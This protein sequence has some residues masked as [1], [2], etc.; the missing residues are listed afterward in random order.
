MKTFQDIYETSNSDSEL[1]SRSIYDLKIILEKAYELAENKFFGSR[2]IFDVIEDSPI[3]L[4]R[5]TVG[6]MLLEVDKL[7]GSKAFM[8]LSSKGI[9]IMITHL[10]IIQEY[11]KELPGDEEYARLI[12]SGQLK[13]IMRNMVDNIRDGVVG[14][15]KANII[16]RINDIGDIQEKVKYLKR[17]RLF[18]KQNQKFV[19]TKQ[20]EQL[21]E[22]IGFEQ[23]RLELD[24]TIPKNSDMSQAN[25]SVSVAT[26]G[27]AN[28]NY[29]TGAVQNLNTGANAQQNVTSGETVNQSIGTAQASS[30]DEL[31]KQL[32]HLI[33]T[34]DA[35]AA[36]RKEM[37]Q[38]LETV[39]VQLQKPEPKKGVV[40]RAFESITELAADGAGVMAGHAIFELLHKAPELLAAAG[41]G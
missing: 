37:E 3:A 38:Q 2:E 31:L 29:A 27:I 13:G 33:V 1:I 40:K 34:D 32:T 41:L 12:F 15:I 9:E 11:L 22:F 14:T 28:F 25:H 36:S 16:E 8:C 21:I 20:Q 18:Y 10:F 19:D 5:T 7:E 35:F 23:E 30:I 17:L 4:H 6:R 26:G 24:L 39:K